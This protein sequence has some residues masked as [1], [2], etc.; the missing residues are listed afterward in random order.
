MNRLENW[1]NFKKRELL[2]RFDPEAFFKKY[3]Y[4]DKWN[5]QSKFLLVE[6]TNDT[7]ILMQ[8]TNQYGNHIELPVALETRPWLNNV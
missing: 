3:M 7:A 8:F 2:G 5:H 6:R 4:T 1:F